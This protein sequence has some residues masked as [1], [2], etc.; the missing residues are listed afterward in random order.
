MIPL[1]GT[2][3]QGGSKPG[4]RFE[5]TVVISHVGASCV[6]KEPEHLGLHT[7]LCQLPLSAENPARVL[8]NLVQ[9]QPLATSLLF[10]E[11]VSVIE[12]VA[13]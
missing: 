1:L 3:T 4:L 12:L 2:G 11:Q 13:C 10:S 5:N 6:L 8:R 9:A 7:D